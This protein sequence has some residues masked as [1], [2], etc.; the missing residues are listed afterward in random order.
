M[1]CL[2]ASL[3][4]NYCSKN[5]VHMVTFDQHLSN[6]RITGTNIR[7]DSINTADKK[8]RRYCSQNTAD[9]N[10]FDKKYF[11]N[12]DQECLKSYRQ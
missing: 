2:C 8:Y 1:I 4:A 5:L 3:S 9:K 7:V 6:S 12:M 11:T 10:N